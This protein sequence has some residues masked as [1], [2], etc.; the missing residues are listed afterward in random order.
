MKTDFKSSKSDYDLANQCLLRSG[1]SCRIYQLQAG[2]FDT[3][4]AE[5]TEIL[6]TII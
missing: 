4:S 5:A 1:M 3:L 2:F 6:K